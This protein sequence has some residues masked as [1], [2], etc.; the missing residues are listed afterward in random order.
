[1]ACEE[2]LKHLKRGKQAWNSWR[3][4][5]PSL[6]PDLSGTNLSNDY[7]GS[8][9]R[10]YDLIGVNFD[11]AT[12]VDVDFSD[13]DTRKATFKAADLRGATFT[14]GGLT[15]AQFAGANLE[16]ASLPRHIADF[17]P[18]ETARQVADRARVIFITLMLATFYSLMTIWA[19]DDFDLGFPGGSSTLPIFNVAVPTA[20][21]LILAPLIL[22]FGFLYLHLYLHNLWNSV[23]VL[24]A[25]FPDGLSLDRKLQDWLLGSVVRDFLPKRFVKGSGFLGQ[26][27]VLLA[28]VAGW[29]WVPLV[30]LIFWANSLQL[31]GITTWILAVL[32]ITSTVTASMLFYAA[33]TVITNEGRRGKR[34][35]YVGLPCLVIAALVL[36]A[37]YFF[38]YGYAP[39]L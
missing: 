14:D 6:E 36:Y 4:Q 17:G 20:S 1:M 24:P 10:G 16:M 30:V 19:A 8:D 35:I 34:S 28:K 31:R 15:P 12:L 21:F 2:H 33:S 9:L 23:L 5:H 7:A 13:S 37:T 18:L 3:H 27:Q 26:S 22:I 25:V 39:F 29:G 38:H 11:F 32:A